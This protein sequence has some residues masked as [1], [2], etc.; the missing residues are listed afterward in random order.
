M[1][2][3]NVSIAEFDGA[4][5][6]WDLHAAEVDYDHKVAR[7]R[8]VKVQLFKDLRVSAVCQ[9]PAADFDTTTRDLTL[10]GPVRVVAQD[11]NAVLSAENVTWSGATHKAVAH[12]RIEIKHGPSQLLAYGLEADTASSHVVLAGPI[13]GRF[14]VAHPGPAGR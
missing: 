3:S 8:S 14:R 7:L 1:S 5:R 13:D 11:G 4:T 2:F 12:G 6:L 9:A 10:L